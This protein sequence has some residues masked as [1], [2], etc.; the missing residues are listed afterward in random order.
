MAAKKTKKSDDMKEEKR[1]RFSFFSDMDPDKKSNM[2]KC[3]GVA[4][5]VFVIFTFLSIV[6]YLFTWKADQS[7]LSQEDMMA[8]GVEVGNWGGK[9]GY[10][11]SRFL[12]SGF[13]GL[14]S[15]AFVFLLGAVA[16]RLFFW[17]RS[18]GLMKTSLITVS[19][20]FIASLILS[21]FGS[22]NVFGGGLGG[23]AGYAVVSGMKNLFGSVVTVC[24]LL[25]LSVV[26]L[27]FVSG[28]FSAWFART[29]ERDSSGACPA[30]EPGQEDDADET[31]AAVPDDDDL[32]PPFEPEDEKAPWENEEDGPHYVS[33]NEG[34]VVDGDVQVVTDE[35]PENA[36]GEIS[37]G[38]TAPSGTLAVKAAVGETASGGTSGNAAGASEMEVVVDYDFSAKVTK[39]LPRIDNR[40][41]LERFTFPPLDLLDDYAGGQHQV[42]QQE[43]DTNNNMIRATLQNYRVE[44][45]KV[46]AV[47]GPTVTLYK[48]VPAPGV[49]VSSIENLHRE[50][51]MALNAKGVRIVTLPDCVGIE[52][53]NSTPSIVP[54]KAMFND[55]AFRESKAE[56]P[57]AIGY[58]ITKRVK[59]FDLADAPHLLIAGATKQGKSVGLNVIVSSLLYAKHPS[60]LKFVFID[61]KMVEFTA[62]ESLIKHYLAVLPLAASEQDERAH[63]IVKDP[64]SAEEILNS[65]CMEMDERYKLLALAG[66]NNLKLIW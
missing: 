38:E 65:L 8:A 41:E 34:F 40:E 49:K 48:V 50:I 53:A 25:A 47:V 12:V 11:W 18:I 1:P 63:A 9:I 35:N 32:D 21:V 19:G 46:T 14:G 43:L 16:Y 31:V 62:Y 24:I 60:E 23:D 36:V 57:V 44:V 33:S 55:A 7:L 17:Q 51:A 26:W 30:A 22:G 52:V 37:L 6:S 13:L 28:R 58:T 27:L 10:K 59:I 20:A 5:F 66:V 29:G 2:L 3:A 54:L 4:V 39:E 45:T 56:L 61:P 15:F 42:S 64:K